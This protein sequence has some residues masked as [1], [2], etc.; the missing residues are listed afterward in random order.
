[1]SVER[2]V[3]EFDGLPDATLPAWQLARR[4]RILDAAHVVLT[5]QEYEQIQIRDVAETAQVARATLYRYFPSKEYLYAC[6]LH[7]WSLLGNAHHDAPGDCTAEDRLR[8]YIHWVLGL[9][10]EQPHFFKAVVAMQNTADPRARKLVAQAVERS[11]A[12]L[13]DLLAVLGPGRAADNATMIWAIIQTMT[14]HALRGNRKLDEVH[15]IID[16]FIDPI[17]PEPR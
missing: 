13:T 17:A 12:K 3:D 7:E 8:G 6:V 4:Q 1:M 16:R 15:R 5:E 14:T 2:G 11:L 9:F 10:E